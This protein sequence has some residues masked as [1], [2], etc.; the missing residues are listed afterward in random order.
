M[1]E[2]KTNHVSITTEEAIESLIFAF[3]LAPACV[4]VQKSNYHLYAQSELVGGIV[5]EHHDTFR[6]YSL[7]QSSPSFVP[8]VSQLTQTTGLRPLQGS[9]VTKQ[10]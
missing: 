2:S 4:A 1:E 10:Q 8:E 9:T 7:V 3:N 5:K 6:C